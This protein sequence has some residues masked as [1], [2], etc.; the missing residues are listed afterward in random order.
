[1]KV[2][3]EGDNITF[4]DDAVQRGDSTAGYTKAN[5][6]HAHGHRV[7]KYADEEACCHDGAGEENEKGWP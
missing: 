5:A 2:F 4:D 7:E 3:N 1:M 6:E